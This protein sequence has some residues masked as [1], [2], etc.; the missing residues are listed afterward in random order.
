MLDD[1][2]IHAW[3]AAFLHGIAPAAPSGVGPETYF[4]KPGYR[5]RDV[6]EY[7]VGDSSETT[8]RRPPARSAQPR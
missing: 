6:P 4:L 1:R 3:C 2:V 8:R 5:S 7:A